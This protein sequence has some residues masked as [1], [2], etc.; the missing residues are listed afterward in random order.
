MTVTL[1][2]ESR[3][4]IKWPVR[5]NREPTLGCRGRPEASK[6]MLQSSLQK[7]WGVREVDTSKSA[8]S[9]VQDLTVYLYFEKSIGIYVFK[10]LKGWNFKTLE[11]YTKS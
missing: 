11:G 9:K 10:S 7:T 1:K 5:I 2:V 4:S 3:T 8:K 6:L